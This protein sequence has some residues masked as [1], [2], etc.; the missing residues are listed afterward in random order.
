MYY[1]AVKSLL[2]DMLL[3]HGFPNGIFFSERRN[4]MKKCTVFEG[5]VSW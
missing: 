4:T 3:L 2:A 5:T 1:V